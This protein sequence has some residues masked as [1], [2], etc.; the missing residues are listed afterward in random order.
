MAS[1]SRSILLV[2]VVLTCVVPNLAFFDGLKSSLSEAKKYLDE[3][4]PYV[5]DG[6]KMVER[7]EQFIDSTI[8]EECE[9]ECRRG[10]VKRARKGHQPKSNGC[11]SLNVLFDDSDQ[12]Y[13]FVEKVA[14]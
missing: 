4:T 9:F 7:A 6:L 12:S 5:V 8:G 2:V 13:I 11:G 10:L 14:S 3:V 1:P